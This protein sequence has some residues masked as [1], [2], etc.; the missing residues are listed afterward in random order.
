M[1]RARA[2]DLLGQFNDRMTRV[3]DAV[4][5]TSWA[6]IEEIVALVLLASQRVVTTRRLA[7]TS[8]LGRRAVSRL[9]LRLQAEG[10]IFS[11]AAQTD[12]R[13]VE[14]VLTKTG[15]EKASALRTKTAEFFSTNT[16]IAREISAGM[17]TSGP[18]QTGTAH[19]DA[20]DLLLRICEA[21]ARLVG[22]MPAA[23]T[24]GKLA[25]RQRAALVLIATQGGARPSDLAGPLE[26]SAAGAAH[27]IDQL[28]TKGF[29]TRV[30]DTVPGDRRA[31]VIQVTPAGLHAIGAVAYGIE[32][33]SA[34]L[35]SLFA[36]LADWQQR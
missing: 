23:A 29:A 8:G 22:Y 32:Q 13:S 24:R 17:P 26:L 15:E 20:L 9:V 30:R 7:D 33:E 28:C 12:A 25:A 19:A 34:L 11:R 35:A 6:E 31:V 4:F 21:G 14:V 3:V 5:G 10:V 1:A 36:E 2:I 27:V 16:E 18:R